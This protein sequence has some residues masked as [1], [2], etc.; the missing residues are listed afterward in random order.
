MG[1]DII[2]DAADE[3]ACLFCNTTDWAFGPVFH[4]CEEGMGWLGA[5]EVAERFIKWLPDDPR[6]YD[7]AK[8]RLKQ[9]EFLKELPRLLVEEEQ[10]DED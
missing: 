4:M 2:A 3:R 8:L 9:V 10:D 7:D 6:H 5:Y 1:V